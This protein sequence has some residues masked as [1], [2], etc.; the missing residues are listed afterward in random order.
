M[1]TYFF[2]TSAIVKRYHAEPGTQR[3]DDILDAG[4]SDIIV[5]SLLIVETVSAFRRKYNMNE[6]SESEMNELIGIFFREVLSD[7]VIVPLHESLLTFTFDLILEDDLRTL[8]SL[9]LSVGLSIDNELEDTT[10]VTADGDLADIATE[11]GLPTIVP[12]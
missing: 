2:D 12:E 1:P 4:E 5:S 6:V 3:V 9:Q 8:D 7:F 11:R 10:F